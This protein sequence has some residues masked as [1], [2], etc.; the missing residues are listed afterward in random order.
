MPNFL[1]GVET[2]ELSN[3][4]L[5]VVAVKSAIIGLVGIA[6]KGT[7]N[8]L[9]LVQSQDHAAQFGSELTGF[10]IPQAI[11]AIQA[12]GP[13]TIFVVN[14]FDPA[15]HTTAVTAESVTVTN[16]KAKTAFAPVGASA[17]I[18]THTS[19]T[20]V[21]V[22]GTDY[23][24]DDFGNIAILA[25]I[26]TI[27]EAAVLKVTYAKLDATLITADVIKGTNV[28]GVKT[29]FKCFLDAYNQLGARPKILIAPGY[30][31]VNA[32]ATQMIVEANYYK[33]VCLLDAPTGTTVTGAI[34]A[35]GPAGS[36]NFNTSDGRTILLE[37][38]N[39]KAYD[40]ATNATVNRPY[41]QFFAGVMAANDSA[42][43]YWYSPS[44]T[45]IKGVLGSEIPVTAAINDPNTEANALN[46]IGITTVFNSGTSGLRTW[47][48]RFASYPSVDKAVGF[49]PVRRT[50]DIVHESVELSML[51][52]VDQP[53]NN[54]TIDAVRQSVQGFINSLIGRGALMVGSEITF[55]P[56]K[57]PPSELAAGRAKWTIVFMSP[58]PLER[59]TFES[60]ID[61]S[62][63]KSIGQPTS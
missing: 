32:V 6:P 26:G 25:P 53:I 36:L 62:L 20:P 16:R 55:D 45:I 33:A 24:I 13:A 57:N 59:M 37:P 19:G 58:P 7:K 9:T 49:I 3:S 56:A 35:R 22:A 48:N 51:D 1:H 4:P 63:L 8:V 10:S 27:A 52:Y 12:Q 21:Y 42:N 38:G 17:P 54:G 61:T 15:T 39:L 14:V 11:A 60:F 5:N 44:N 43:G 46:E 30:S 29:G 18:V 40:V 28:S 41:S 2:V 34:T 50:A 31:S 47:G 23:T